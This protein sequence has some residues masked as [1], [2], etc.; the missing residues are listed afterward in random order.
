MKVEWL[1]WLTGTV[2]VN[3]SRWITA[4]FAWFDSRGSSRCAFNFSHLPFLL[5]GKML[6]LINCKN[7]KIKKH[8]SVS[9]CKNKQ[10]IAVTSCSEPS[11]A[12]G[13]PIILGC[14]P[15]IVKVLITCL[16]DRRNIRRKIWSN[17]SYIFL[18]IKKKKKSTL[19]DP[20]LPEAHLWQCFN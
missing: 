4:T 15:L 1:S 2:L 9:A 10:D 6:L 14:L 19:T 18:L 7:K 16:D 11:D 17:Q 5:R 20:R 8:F 3:R 12:C 13:L